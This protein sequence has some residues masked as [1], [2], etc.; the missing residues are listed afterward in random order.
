M[1][2]GTEHRTRML[3]GYFEGL[4]GAEVVTL[5]HDKLLDAKMEARGLPHADADGLLNGAIDQCL[6]M[7]EVWGEGCKERNKRTPSFR[8]VVRRD[9]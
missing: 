8:R 7:M 6:E 9:R 1:S 3:F 5:V 4:A 2:A